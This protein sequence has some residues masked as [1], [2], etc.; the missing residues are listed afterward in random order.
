[1]K[2]CVYTNQK[3]KKIKKWIDGFIDIKQKKIYIYDENKKQIYTSKVYSIEE[4]IIDSPLYIIQ[5]DD[6]NSTN[7]DKKDL[8]SDEKLSFYNYLKDDPENLPLFSKNVQE[9]IKTDSEVR[10]QEGRANNDIL[11]LFKR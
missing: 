2:E 3:T 7:R 4:D 8:N 9:K 10:A 5:C 11:N 6:L 1:M